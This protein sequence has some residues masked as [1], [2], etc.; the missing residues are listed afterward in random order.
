MLST[1]DDFVFDCVLDLRVPEGRVMISIL[2][3]RH[4]ASTAALAALAALATLAV[5]SWWRARHHISGSVLHVVEA[6]FTTSSCPSR[7]SG[8]FWAAPSPPSRWASHDHDL[9]HLDCCT[10]WWN[11]K[12]SVFVLPGQVI[13]HAHRIRRL[14]LTGSLLPRRVLTT[15]P[16]SVLIF[17]VFR[18]GVCCES[19][20]DSIFE[21][22]CIASNCS[23][24]DRRLATFKLL[25]YCPSHWVLHASRSYPS[26]YSVLLTI[27][28]GC[29]ASDLSCT[30]EVWMLTCESIESLCWCCFLNSSVGFRS[31]RL[32][33]SLTWTRAFC[34]LLSEHSSATPLD[35]PRLCQRTA[36]TISQHQLWL[37]LLH[38]WHIHNLILESACV[39]ASVVWIFQM[40][41]A[42]LCITTEMS[43]LLAL[44]TLSWH[45]MA[46]S[47]KERFLGSSAGGTLSLDTDT[48]TTCRWFAPGLHLR[49]PAPSGS[50]TPGV[51]S[52]RACR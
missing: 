10:R 14:R 44:S 19:P 29:S 4:L 18:K 16:L 30:S 2:P 42:C 36:P 48:S 32:C 21:R 15:A 31:V 27:A 13:V 40:V 28:R 49:W 41:V 20:S 47:V 34:L 46:V 24:L 43:S 6:I 9:G 17:G 52:R 22:T 12:Q 1:F 23:V 3:D 7:C 25:T 37:S 33:S 26:N 50:S 5:S 35:L 39:N 11:W 45:C 38:N 8:P 51:A